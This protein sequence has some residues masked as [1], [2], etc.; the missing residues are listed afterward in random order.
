[1]YVHAC[2][3]VTEGVLRGQK[4]QTPLSWSYYQL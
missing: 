2:A 4:G 1:M 3:Y